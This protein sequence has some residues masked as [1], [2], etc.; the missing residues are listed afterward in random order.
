LSQPEALTASPSSIIPS[1]LDK[2]KASTS[3][4]ESASR[5]KQIYETL[6]TSCHGPDGEGVK[7]GDKLLAPAFSKSHWFKNDGRVSVLARIVLQGQTGP[8]DGAKYGEGLM[9][10]LESTYN[11]EQIAGVLNFIGERWHKWSKP[12]EASAIA[13]VRGEI[14]DRHTPWTYEELMA[15]QFVK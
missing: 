13:R 10:P 15:L 12:I 6:C 4:G 1:L 2:L 7:Q 14:A 9:V 3:L 8:I 5:G 11:D